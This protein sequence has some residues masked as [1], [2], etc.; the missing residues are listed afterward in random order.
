MRLQRF[1]DMLTPD[2][3]WAYITQPFPGTPFFDQERSGV[4]DLLALPGGEPLVLERS[5]SS[6]LFRSRIYEVDFAGATDTPSIVNLDLTP[7]T[8]VAKTLLWERVGGTE[9]YEGLTLGPM[10]DDGDQ[11][12]LLVS[13]NGGGSSQALHA[14][15]ITHVPE[16]ALLLQLEAGCGLLL[17]MSRLRRR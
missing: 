3:Q 16:P 14:L 11:S 13:D 4:S 7:F 8:P 10:L 5:F 15:R 6:V 9:N 17:V 12:L 2:G 1:D